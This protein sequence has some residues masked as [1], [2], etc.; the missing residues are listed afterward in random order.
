MKTQ[1]PEMVSDSEG[2]G[3]GVGEVFASSFLSLGKCK[4][5]CFAET[6][7]YTYALYPPNKTLNNYFYYFYIFLLNSI[8]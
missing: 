4:E 3:E 1:K 6:Y 2:E 7:L 8:L 5:L